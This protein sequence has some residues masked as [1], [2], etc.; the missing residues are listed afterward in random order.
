MHRGGGS[1]KSSAAGS[2]ADL[3]AAN[4]R[5]SA[6]NACSPKAVRRLTAPKPQIT[7]SVWDARYWATKVDLRAPARE[8]YGSYRPL[9]S[10]RGSLLP[11]RLE[12]LRRVLERAG[13]RLK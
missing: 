13:T 12:N 6:F 4:E 5:M 7:E 3:R 8:H 10:I 9:S 2:K 1:K 11:R